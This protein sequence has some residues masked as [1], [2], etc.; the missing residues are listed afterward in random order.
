MVIII[1]IDYEPPLQVR[2]NRLT[3]PISVEKEFKPCIRIIHP[4]VENKSRVE[5]LKAIKPDN[6]L[7]KPRPE[8]LHYFQYKQECIEQ[9][10]N[11]EKEVNN[12][13][14]VKEEMRLMTKIGFTEKRSMSNLS[15]LKSHKNDDKKYML[16]SAYWQKKENDRLNALREESDQIGRDK[17]YVKTLNEW[18]NKYLPKIK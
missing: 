17:V 15:L 8:K 11:K 7:K 2:R 4:P 13:G 10:K 12:N 9:I 6:E 5:S 1:N 3:G 16:T 14:R 18:D